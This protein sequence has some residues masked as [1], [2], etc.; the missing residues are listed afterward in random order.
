MLDYDGTLAPFV[1]KRDEAVPHPGVR[2]R[3]RVMLDRG[4]TRVVIV[5]GRAVDDLLPLLDLN[6]APEI[7]GSH[8]WERRLPSGERLRW[9][10]SEAQR[11]ALQEAPERLPGVDLEIKP[12]SVAAHWRGKDDHEAQRLRLR[13]EE[14][15]GDL[16]GDEEMELHRF[17]G[18]LELRARGRTKGS[19]IEEI[20]ADETSGLFAAY[21]GDDLTDEDAFRA[22]GDRGLPVLVR[23]EPRASAARAWINPPDELLAFLDTWMENDIDA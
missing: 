18:G 17:D 20:L 1:E 8:G 9:P 21:L 11:R 19:A 12:I 15:W 7:W 23:A 10:L 22:L 2:E 5:S 3:L 16:V 4:R 14:A 6:P 13:A